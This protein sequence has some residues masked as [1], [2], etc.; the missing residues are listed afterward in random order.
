MA[1]PADQ[2]QTWLID[3]LT[4]TLDTSREVRSFAEASL[5]QASLQP[6][7]GAA[8][9]KITVN[10]DIPFG[11][12]Q[13]SFSFEIICQ[14][15]KQHWEEGEENFIYPVVSPEEKRIMHQ[16]LL[17]SLDDPNRKIRTAISMAVVSIAQ[18]DWPDDWPELLPFL[19]KLISEQKTING[20]H[21]ALK[22]LALLSGELD[23]TL[24]PKLLPALY[25]RLHSII[26][27]PH[28]Y[29]KSLR[30][31]ALAIVHSCISVLGS[32]SGVYKTET[33]GLMLEMVNSLMEQFSIILQPP[34]Q[35]E[36]PDEWSMRMEVLKCLL[37]LVQ[38]FP[39]LIEARFSVILSSLWQTF[40][41]ALDV[42]QISSIHRTEDSG[43]GRFDSDG[44][45]RSLDA[46]IIQLFETLL[47]IVGNSKLAKVIGG[48]IKELVYYTIAFLQMTEEQVHTWLL[49]ANQYVADENDV[50][51]SCR[52]SG[53]L[54]LEEIA[55]A[56]GGEMIDS[57]VEAV[58]KRFI[59]S[60]TAK[61]SG[62][63]DWWKLREASFFA[64]ASISEQLIEAQDSGATKVNLSRLLDEMVAEDIR[65][66][67][68]EFPFLHARAFSVVSK[69]SSV[70]GRNVREQ[71]LYAAAQ[72]IALDVPPPVKVGACQVLSQVLPD[73]KSELVQPHIMC[74]LSSLIDLLKQASD[75]T[76]HLVLETLQAAIKAGHELSRSMEPVI[77]PVILDVWVHHIS[78]PFISIE[79]LEVLEAIKD[80][81]GCM[82]PLVSR[83]LPSIASIL[84]NPRNQPDG[85][86]AGSFD[87]LTMILKSAPVEVVKAVFDRCFNSTIQVVLESDD[88]GEMQNATECLAAFLAAGKH[89]LLSWN[90]DPS[91]TMKR[92]LDAASRLL[93][94]NL[95]SSGSL[96]VG[97]YVLQLIFHFPS[98]MAFHIREL[99]A[100]VVR[101]MQSSE[102][103]GLKCS[104][105]VVLAR[106]VHF[107]SPDVSQF[108]NLLLT[109]PTKDHENSFSYVMSEW[110]KLQGEIQGAYQ[111]K[112]TT[113]A[114][115][116]LLSS[117]HEE[118]VKVNVNGHLIKSNAG[119]TTRS[120]AKLA[121]DQWTI[122]PLHA[123]IFSLLSDA[124]VET[125]EQIL[126]DDS[127]SDED[128]DW[129][130]VLDNNGCGLQDLLYQSNVPSKRNS[131]VEHLN[132]MAKVFNESDG[133]NSEEELV[134]DD[135]L[136]ET[137]LAG[138]LTQFFLNLHDMD[139][140]L[141]DH[142]C[143]NLT[144]AQRIAVKKVVRK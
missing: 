89:E 130:E 64:M 84:E 38:N 134:K 8:L 62:S 126:D 74:I 80:A 12:R 117:R 121:P 123:K 25:P 45:E 127:G 7:Y 135:P 51:Y 116:L 47:T 37:Q 67:V 94:P 87:L 108:I 13:I 104:L 100:A 114:L 36:D 17:P 97:N 131:S 143:Q 24:V 106:L 50:T 43:S 68:Y 27:A 30:T 41:S 110:T 137:K 102:I 14:F 42:Y 28:L 21:G 82:Q 57:I 124:L 5:Q 18:Y 98:E 3:C 118:L 26:S 140:S 76:L 1:S 81:P 144:H 20:V 109:V 91:F 111:I 65:T 78:D 73:A 55:N 34:L 40:V 52:V 122:I 49:D 44:N 107:S 95:E 85:L 22:C 39:S 119:I 10:K 60:Q 75:E 69:F 92:L 141:F 128:S 132:A 2:D 105:I 93:D 32:M 4:A 115:A 88:H 129:E 35:S 54:L 133:D 99:V 46:F 139:S 90:G 53:S 63:T 96:F 61:V 59:E 19:L 125:Q 66:A 11:L 58:N 103:A 23:D 6:G 86:L 33:A 16:L 79:A 142:L 138:F 71:F 77:S 113:T 56:Y 29:E 72:A 101:R 112:V 31:K 9:T 70:I 15:I 136:N 48:S 83:I 120:K